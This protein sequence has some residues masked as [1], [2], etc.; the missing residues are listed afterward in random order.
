MWENFN[1]RGLYGLTAAAPPSSSVNVTPGVATIAGPGMDD[2]GPWYAPDHPLFVFGV[3]LAAAAGL[4][5][6]AGS[7]RV[8]PAHVGG[9][10]G[11]T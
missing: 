2:S 10:V 6:F 1:A 9:S 3:L 11:R 7:A 8:G 5:G 4:I